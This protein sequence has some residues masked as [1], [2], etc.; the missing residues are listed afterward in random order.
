[1]SLARLRARLPFVVFV[2]L[3]VLGLMF[4]GFACACA[5]DHPGQAAD[6]ATSVI[7]AAPPLVELWSVTAVGLIILAGFVVGRG[8]L[9]PRSLASLQR[10]LF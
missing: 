7:A 4:L 1:M 5:T 3:L 8:A 9:R 10:F 6:R 2:L